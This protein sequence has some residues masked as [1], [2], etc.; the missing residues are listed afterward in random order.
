MHNFFVF[1]SALCAT[2]FNSDI[3]IIA[4]LLTMITMDSVLGSIVN[5]NLG[6][7]HLQFHKRGLLRESSSPDSSC[8]ADINSEPQHGTSG[9]VHDSAQKAIMKK[10][11]K[12]IINDN[13]GMGAIPLPRIN[14]LPGGQFQHSQLHS[15]LSQ[16]ANLRHQHAYLV[17]HAC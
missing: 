3:N 15:Q 11:R 2:F 7:S 12:H 14:E 5:K 9:S 13:A 16:Y 4:Q 6:S 10:N 8:K 17:M 1:I